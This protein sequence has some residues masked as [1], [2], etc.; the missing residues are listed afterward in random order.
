SPAAPALLEALKDKSVRTG[1]LNTLQNVNLGPE[2]EAGVPALIDCL[3]SDE[4]YV[5]QHAAWVLGR[6][7]PS[8]RSALAVLTQALKDLDGD[9]AK[10]AAW[11]LESIEGE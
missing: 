2:A 7:S 1:V 6:T 3:K 5:R 10:A 11:G 8:A 4:K 9:V